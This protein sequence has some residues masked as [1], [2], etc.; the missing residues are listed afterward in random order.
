MISSEYI[1]T[2]RQLLILTA[3]YLFWGWATAPAQ[4]ERYRAWEIPAVDV[5]RDY[6]LKAGPVYFDLK[7]SLDIHYDSNLN[8]SPTDAVDDII[9]NPEIS[10]GA[11]WEFSPLNALSLDFGIGYEKYLENSELDSIDNFLLLSPDSELRLNM[12]IGNLSLQFFDGLSYM[13]DATDTLGVDGNG[14]PV[15]NLIQYGRWSNRVG[16]RGYY[17]LNIVDMNFEVA[18]LDDFPDDDQ[19]DFRR[20]T[21][22]LF[23]GSVRRDFAANLRGGLSF[24]YSDIAYENSF[25]NDGKS[26]SIGP[27]GEWSVSEYVSLS[28]GLTYVIRDFETGGANGDTT[29]LDGLSATLGI[30][31]EVNSFFNHFLS[32]SRSQD[33]GFVS[34]SRET[35]VYSYRFTLSGITRWQYSGSAAYEEGEDSGGLFAERYDRYRLGLRARRQ[36]GPRMFMELYGDYSDKASDSDGRSYDRFRIGATLNYDF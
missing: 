33:Y 21:E 28:G 4:V 35:D 5:Y 20:K 2:S 12:N 25:Q 29:N 31:H 15:L 13:T 8:F 26:Y 18:R 16:M 36:L 24:S 7:G 22:Y 19:F 27:F 34:N 9:I 10:F 11:L 1:S 3:C 30:R 6:N 32:F 23:R 17:A 14:D